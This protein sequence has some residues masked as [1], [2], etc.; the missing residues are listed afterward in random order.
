MVVH[1]LYENRNYDIHTNGELSAITKLGR[2]TDAAIVFDVGANRGDWTDSAAR[3]FPRARIHSFEILPETFAHLRARFGDTAGIA[4]NNVGLSDAEGTLTVYF[5]PDRD[6]LATCVVGFSEEFHNYRP[7]S[8]PVSVTTGDRYCAARG[9]DTIDFLKVDVEGYEP[10]VLRGFSGMLGRGSIGAI[11]FE[12]GYIN[13]DTHFL[14]KD[15]YAYLS[16]F[17]M[18][19]GKIYPDYVDFRPYRHVHEDFYGPNYLAVRAD[20]QDLLRLLSNP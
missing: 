10:Q 19:I 16:P 15:F 8:C 12:Y 20:R 2:V 5:S 14:L 4:I 9:I 18:V 6:D 17:N 1:Q 13:I 11:Q 7:R 3:T